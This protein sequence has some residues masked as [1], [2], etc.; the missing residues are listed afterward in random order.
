[1]SLACPSVGWSVQDIVLQN[2]MHTHLTAESQ[3]TQA[4]QNITNFTKFMQLTNLKTQ[5]TK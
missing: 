2:L 5:K 4:Q 3:D 1:M